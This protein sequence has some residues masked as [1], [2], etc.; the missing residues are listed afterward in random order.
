MYLVC[1]FVFLSNTSYAQDW[2]NL[3]RYKYDNTKLGL[4][5]Q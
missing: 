4:P 5:Q 1:F 2:A 3:N